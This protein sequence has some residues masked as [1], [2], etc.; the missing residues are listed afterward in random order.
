MKIKNLTPAE[1]IEKMNSVHAKNT[2]KKSFRYRNH[3]ET[4]EAWVVAK[5]CKELG[6]ND[7]KITAHNGKNEHNDDIDILIVNGEKQFPV[8]IVEAVEQR[9]HRKCNE[10]AE[11]HSWAEEE[12]L[13]LKAIKKKLNKYKK[14]ESLWL[15]VYSNIHAWIRSDRMNLSRLKKIGQVSGFNTVYLLTQNDIITG[16]EE[17]KLEA[18][19]LH[20]KGV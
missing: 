11:D 19:L 3:D 14:S 12:E 20:G 6:L 18:K 7:A 10:M 9:N 2:D 5:L 13:I 15:V 1:V 8:Q 4:R 17:N 16:T